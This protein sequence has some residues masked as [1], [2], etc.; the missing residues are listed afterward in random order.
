MSP[1]AKPLW[2]R[3]LIFVLPLML[4][5]IMQS[6][7]GTINNVYVGQLL[8]VDAL[9]AV[10][11]FFPI[12]ML[13]IAFVIGL[14]SGSTVLIGQA[15][16]A[17]NLL[18]VK[19]VSGTTIAISF[20]AGMV[21]ALLGGFA[22]EPI[23]VLLGAPPN[24]LG[25]AVAYGRAMLIGMP[26]L[27]V[28]M[29][30]T[31]ILRGVGDAMTPMFS[32]GLSIL[33]GLVI[34]PALIL[35]WGGLPRLG[36]VSAAIATIIGFVLVLAFLFVYLRWRRH[37]MAP[38]RVLLEALRVDMRL[39]RQ[40][41]RLGVPAGVQMIFTSVAAIVII[42][43]VNTFGSDATAAYGAV[44]QVMSYVQ[45]P[46][47]SIAIAGSIF[48]AQAIGARQIAEVAHVTR[49]ALLLNV[50]ITGGLVLIAYLF[51]E[52]LVGLF[53]TDPAVI[54]VTQNLLHIVLWSVVMFGLAQVLSGVMRASGDVVIPMLLA[55]AAIV[56]V[57]VPG[58]LLLSRVFGLPG[59]WMAF[60]ATFTSMLVLQALY[61]Q[62]VWRKKEIKALV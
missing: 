44:N 22:A 53:I 43:I 27:F 39:L 24:V 52:H 3:F 42:G 54:E 59:V 51:S 19:Q 1:Q 32:L 47:M 16:G 40:I 29:V 60:A 15:W 23:L 34:T 8:G 45:F 30:V 18:K 62:F 17:E 21:V 11:V 48:A 26:A 12:M 61:Y 49:T 46:A 13:L 55:L 28:F 9:A 57:E 36:V 4:A 5:N 31:S 37:P 56:L 25:E 35:G 20:L 33:A 50:L 38:D 14:A 41:L 2:L 58:A 10:S 7:S 6:L